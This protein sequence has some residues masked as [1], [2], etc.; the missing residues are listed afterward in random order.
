MDIWEKTGF[1]VRDKY[2]F[3]SA[4]AAGPIWVAMDFFV[5]TMHI[6]GDEAIATALTVFILAGIFTGRYLAELLLIRFKDLQRLTFLITAIF[7]VAGIVLFSQLAFPF[8]GSAAVHL[9]L[10]WVPFTITL[11]S[12]G[13]L[14]KV[15]RAI[16]R[17]ELMEARS[18]AAHNKSE[19]HLLQSQLSPHFLFNTL[20]NL[21]G[22]SITQHEKI[23]PL[24]LK[25][26]D[27][28][29][30]SVYDASE[31]FV[32]LKEEQTY[33]DNYIEFEK[34]RIGDR[35]VLTNDIEKVVDPAVKIAPMLLII[36]IEN[37]FKHSKNTADENIHIEI[38]LKTWQNLILFSIKNSR[39]IAAKKET[40]L[41][42]N[43]G[44]GLVNVKKRL[45]LLY[46][47][48]HE[49]KIEETDTSYLV[50]LRLNA[51]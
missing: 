43:S 46:P 24:L 7:I 35:L 4:V 42:K 19:L 9:L 18:Q 8:E 29:R 2:I 37:A 40:I 45:E 17:N 25:L 1:S 11:M 50:I 10:S 34:I 36:F 51:K 6:P 47:G 14:I 21:Y 33:I 22:L 13:M 26:S 39:S 31:T 27:L 41:D 49:L 30:Y 15:V 48:S 5:N 44:F 38:S 3:L 12:L 23:P 20:N 28:L 16:G 32:P